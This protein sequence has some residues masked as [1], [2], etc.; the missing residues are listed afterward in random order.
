MN[1]MGPTKPRATRAPKTPLPAKAAR[2][3][4][5]PKTPLPAKAAQTITAP[6]DTA[7]WFEPRY[8]TAL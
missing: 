1:H 6:Y 5:A 3:I 2:T 4:T 8:E 7:S